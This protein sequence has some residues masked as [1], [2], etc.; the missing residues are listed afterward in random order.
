METEKCAWARTEI[1]HKKE[2]ETYHCENCSGTNTRCEHYTPMPDKT[3]ITKLTIASPEDRLRGLVKE[4][5]AS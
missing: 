5:L 1:T 2:G 4:L 3:P